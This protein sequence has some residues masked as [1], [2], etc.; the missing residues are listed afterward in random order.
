MYNKIVKEIEY[1]IEPML[2]LVDYSDSFSFFHIM[3]VFKYCMF[4]SKYIFLK[5][6]ICICVYEHIFIFE[7]SCMYI[8]MYLCI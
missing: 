6:N 7:Y 5:V 1:A 2:V 4:M 3:N 8:Y